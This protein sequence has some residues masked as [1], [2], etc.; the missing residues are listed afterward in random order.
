M[1][2]ISCRALLLSPEVID[3]ENFPFKITFLFSNYRNPSP[4][5]V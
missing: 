4:F 1:F 3:E 2:A 5:T